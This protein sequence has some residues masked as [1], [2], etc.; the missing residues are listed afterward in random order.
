MLLF[1][2]VFGNHRFVDIIEFK[3]FLNET[4]IL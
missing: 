3:P 1:L 2:F 4:G